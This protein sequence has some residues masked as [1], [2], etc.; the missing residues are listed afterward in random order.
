MD[1]LKMTTS[2]NKKWPS[3]LMLAMNW[4]GYFSCAPPRAF[5][6]VT[7]KYFFVIVV[8]GKEAVHEV[9]GLGFESHGAQIFFSGMDPLVPVV[10]T[11]TKAW[12]L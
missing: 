7:V 1:I 5:L 12:D 4:G 6:K 11:R 2:V 9:K 8:G 10:A 3:R